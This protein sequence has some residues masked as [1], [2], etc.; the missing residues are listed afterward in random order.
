MSNTAAVVSRQQETAIV[1]AYRKHYRAATPEIHA[2]GAEWYAT[3]Q[4]SA[5]ILWPED[6]ARAAY[7][8]AALSP[9]AQW[10]VNLAWAAQVIYAARNGLEC[11]AVSTT[12]NRAAA[13]RIATG[14]ELTLNGPKVSRFARNIMGD[15][16][17]GTVDAWMLYAAHGRDNVAKDAQ[18]NPKAP[19]GKRYAMYENAIRRAAKLEGTSAAMLQ[20][21]VW[22][23]VRGSAA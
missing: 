18:G 13:W 2:L 19:T 9:R 6:P 12:N 8:I 1:R 15:M 11:P 7:V 17:C 10:K 4:E 16:D 20:A 23:V 21:I 22:T 3:A 14:G 5:R